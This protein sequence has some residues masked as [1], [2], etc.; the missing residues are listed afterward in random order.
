MGSKRWQIILDRYDEESRA[1]SEGVQVVSVH[2]TAE[3]IFLEYTRRERKPIIEV[4]TAGLGAALADILESK[5]IPI[6]T[7]VVALKRIGCA[8]IYQTANSE[9][10]G[11][12]SGKD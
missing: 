1:K 7:T 11:E 2:E 4:C 10:N 8:D 9:F 3:M 5:G 6:L 12:R